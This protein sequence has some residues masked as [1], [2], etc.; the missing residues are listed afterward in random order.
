MA[1]RPVASWLSVMIYNTGVTDQ[2]LAEKIGI[3]K[4]RLGY[5]ATGKC[6]PNEEECEVFS[7][8]FKTDIRDLLAMREE[9]TKM[10]KERKKERLTKHG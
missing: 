1:D 9:E 10:R 8:Y 6:I 3:K 5:L 7:G 2:E 4:L